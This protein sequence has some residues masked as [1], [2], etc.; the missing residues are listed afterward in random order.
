M[1]ARDEAGSHACD[2]YYCWDACVA[3]KPIECLRVSAMWRLARLDTG[4]RSA[5]RLGVLTHWQ[6]RVQRSCL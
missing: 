6:A 4:S 3:R 5:G 2:D 1:R